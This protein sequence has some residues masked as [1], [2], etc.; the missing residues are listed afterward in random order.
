[1]TSINSVTSF[2]GNEVNK[3]KKHPKESLAGYAVGAGVG[4]A[5]VPVSEKILDQMRKSFDCTLEENTAVKKVLQGILDKNNGELASKGVTLNYVS[6]NAVNVDTRPE[7]LKKLMPSPEEQLRQ[8]KNAF[9]GLKSGKI[10]LPENKMVAAGFHEIGH[11]INKNSSKLGKALQLI[12]PLSMLLAGVPLLIGC[13]SKSKKAKDGE[14]LSSGRKFTNFVRNN[15]GKLTFA[16]MLPI[17]LE[18]S[19]ASIKGLKLAKETL[20]PELLKKVSSGN[21]WGFV[22]YIIAAV[23]PAISAYAAVKVKDSMIAKK[24]GR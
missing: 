1:M 22:S 21:K 16:T 11:A 13:F 3:N 14:E 17:L 10:S 4:L 6:A 9:F 15:A 18:E 2:Q 23:V 20:S 19:M 5:S 7:F 24:E 8:G 12:R